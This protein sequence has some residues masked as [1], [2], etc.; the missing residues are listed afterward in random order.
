MKMSWLSAK[1]EMEKL[2]FDPRIV[3]IENE[4]EKYMEVKNDEK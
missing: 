4:D 2:N 3:D 1:A